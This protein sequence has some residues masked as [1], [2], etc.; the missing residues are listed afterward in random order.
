MKVIF[1]NTKNIENFDIILSILKDEN[2]HFFFL[3]EFE[4]LDLSNHYNDLLNLNF[5]QFSNPG[6]DKIKILKRKTIKNV[7]LTIQ[8]NN[9]TGL[10]LPKIDLN[11]ISVHMPSQMNYEFDGLKYN[12]AKFKSDFELHIGDTENENIL[13]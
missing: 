3:S 4:H 9:Y 5:E 2:P 7:E 8:H 1:W 13:I 12:M 6:C 10:Y 11:I